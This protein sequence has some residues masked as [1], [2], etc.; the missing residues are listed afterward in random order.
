MLHVYRFLVLKHAHS[1][2][3]VFILIGIKIRSYEDRQAHKYKLV[4]ANK[5]KLV[6]AN[7]RTGFIEDFQIFLIQ[8]L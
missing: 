5:N 8:K 7:V 2:I 3:K 6:Y 4:Y 1:H